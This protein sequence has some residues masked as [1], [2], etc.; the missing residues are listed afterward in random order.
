MD[1]IS[2]QPIQQ[3]LS[4]QQVPVQPVSAPQPTAP[5]QSPSKNNLLLVLGVLLVIGVTGTIG[6][7][8][9]TQQKQ[10]PAVVSPTSLISPT[11]TPLPTPLNDDDRT[12]QGIDLTTSEDDF[13][14]LQKGI[15]G[16]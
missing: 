8:V 12:L 15:Q 13:N 1:T 7:I 5:V 10:A 16:L 11:V 6:Y 9:F 3:P 4:T 14:D 2:Q